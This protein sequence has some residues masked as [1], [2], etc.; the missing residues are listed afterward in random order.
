VCVKM[1]QWVVCVKMRQWVVCVK[2]RQWVV[3]RQ[4]SP[5]LM[6][7]CLFTAVTS[8]YRLTDRYDMV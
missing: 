3:W 1:R 4:A 2:M 8:T 7:S 5:T 6:I